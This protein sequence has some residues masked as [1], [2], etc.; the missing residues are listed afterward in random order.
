MEVLFVISKYKKH[1]ENLIS[2]EIN[3]EKEKTINEIQIKTCEE[4]ENEGRT[5]INLKRKILKTYRYDCKVELIHS[6]KI[7]TDIKKG[8]IVLISG[9]HGIA[10][11]IEGYVTDVK[12][13]SVVISHVDK[14]IKNEIYK[15]S[16]I[17]LLIRMT[18]YERQKM[19]LRNTECNEV[20]KFLF[21][22]HPK[23]DNDI[24]QIQIKDRKLNKFQQKSVINSLKCGNFFLIHGPFGTGKT[25]TITEIIKQEVEQNHKVLVTAETNIAVDNIAKKFTNSKI[26]VI[27]IGT[28][29]KFANEV[30]G[31][32]LNQKIKANKTFKEIEKLQEKKKNYEMKLESC[33]TNEKQEFIKK[34]DFLNK[35]ISNLKYEINKNIIKHS[36][37]IFSTNSSAAISILNDVRF[38]VAIVDEAA[39]TTIPSILIPLSKAERFI[40]AG[41]HNQLPPTIQN[42]NKELEESLFE[43]LI[44]KFP[45]QCQLLKKQYR[46]N[47]TLMDFPNKEFYNN[48]LISDKSVRN[49]K[50]KKLKSEYDNGKPLIFIDTQNMKNNKELLQNNSNSYVNELEAE[51]SS[52]LANEYINSKISTDVGI[53]ASYANQVKLIRK[54]TTAEVETVDGFQGREKEV[55]IISTVRSNSQRDIGFLDEP[56][57]LNVA[58]TRA[59]KKLIIIGNSK[60]LSTKPIYK[61]LY[62]Y[63]KKENSIIM[64]DKN[65][66]IKHNI[67]T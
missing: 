65:E 12:H 14:T 2:E 63:C 54:M 1:L 29:E 37:I 52:K 47:K 33:L 40:L 39:Q 26:G 56:R 43:K 19:I 30:K 25:K 23:I 9:I 55:I 15:Q 6:E 53:I 7:K 32:S 45:Q 44:K 36:K 42:K 4:L 50:I 8:D 46:M 34:I 17:D 24:N 3:S 67:K 27:R 28:Y 58:L 60:T 11:N 13:N 49:S 20:I 61:R 35:E 5:I 16:R 18:T 38:D 64:G 62:E 10:K 66:F 59:S 31:I 51:L 57:R 21:G 41:D 48:K 22:S